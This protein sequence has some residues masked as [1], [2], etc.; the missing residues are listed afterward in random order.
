MNLRSPVL[1]ALL[2]AATVLPLSASAQQALVPAGSEIRFTSRQ[3]GVPVDGKFKTF[4]AQVAFD[5]AKLATSKIAFTVDTGSATLGVRETDA[6][7]PLPD[8]APAALL[9]EAMHDGR[10]D[11]LAPLAHLLS[12]AE[13]GAMLHDDEARQPIVLAVHD[14]V[15]GGLRRQPAG[16]IVAHVQ[17]QRMRAGG[18]TRPARAAL[19]AALANGRRTRSRRLVAALAIVLA[20]GLPGLVPALHL[21]VRT[22]APPGLPVLVPTP[23]YP[24]FFDA[25]KRAGLKVQELPLSRVNGRWRLL[26]QVLDRAVSGRGQ[27]LLFCN[28]HNPTGTLYHAGELA[29]LAAVAQAHDLRVCSDEI[30]CD[31]LLD[32]GDRHLPFAA[33]SEDAAQ[34]SLVLMAPS[35]SFNLAGLGCSYAL[36][37]NPQLRHQLKEAAHGLLPAVNLF[38]YVAAEA[39]LREGGPWLDAQ[40]RYLAGNRALVNQ[41][42][43]RAG[44]DHS[45]PAAT[46]LS[47][48]DLRGLGVQSP[49]AL[50]EQHGVSLS[51]GA[52]FGGPGHLRLNF[53]C[54]RPLLVQALQRC[55]AALEAAGLTINH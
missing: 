13:L 16:G 30:H 19:N 49:H 5:P 32:E 25:V 50:F 40:C 17:L 41:L 33:I 18:T 6:D 39:A 2:G 42:W 24:P 23:V 37:A 43:Q 3:M 7:T 27:L 1:A 53:G 10:E 45:Q 46:Y 14:P 9:R 8:R 54:A 26:P 4:S 21:I 31:L 36:V 51:D 28:P 11:A 12:P 20:L 47:W 22:F 38:G 48:V 29:E 35:K 44:L 15:A 34:R 55:A 52:P